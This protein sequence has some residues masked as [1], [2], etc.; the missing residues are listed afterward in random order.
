MQL[1]SLVNQL[2]HYKR[3]IHKY[4]SRAFPTSSFP[5][6]YHLFF[7][8]K[9]TTVRQFKK[10]SVRI[11]QLFVHLLSLTH[12]EVQSSYLHNFFARKFLYFCQSR[13]TLKHTAICS[14]SCIGVR[15]ELY[16]SLCFLYDRM[17]VGEALHLLVLPCTCG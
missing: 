4:S 14:L 7:E 10:S 1:F 17:S 16:V 15:C 9:N 8:K 6:F 11:Y 5:H 12:P 3:T 2:C 13:Q